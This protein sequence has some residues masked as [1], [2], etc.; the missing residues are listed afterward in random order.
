MNVTNRTRPGLC[1][2]STWLSYTQ[3][4]VCD[5]LPA[6]LPWPPHRQYGVAA[7]SDSKQLVG[8]A[9]PPC[10]RRATKR[11]RPAV[12]EYRHGWSSRCQ[13]C[14]Q[15]VELISDEVKLHPVVALATRVG[16]ITNHHHCEVCALGSGGGGG[17]AVRR[18]SA[19]HYIQC[20]LWETLPQR[21]GHGDD[22]IWGRVI[23]V[24]THHG[25]LRSAR[26]WIGAVCQGAHHCHF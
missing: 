6:L 3:H 26:L 5:C 24:A 19:R 10:V 17:H 2:P 21:C 11:G 12:D 7:G 22:L 23:E 16:C 9:R 25:F 8:P 18:P 14:R 15:E 13:Y 1:Q 4:N 20:I